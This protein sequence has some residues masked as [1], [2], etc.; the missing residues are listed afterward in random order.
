M[1]FLIDLKLK[2]RSCEFIRQGHAGKLA[3]K[4]SVNN[5]G[6]IMRKV[7][8]SCKDARAYQQMYQFLLAAWYE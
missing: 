3:S 4:S 1:K 8:V 6:K 5:T 7:C 2:R